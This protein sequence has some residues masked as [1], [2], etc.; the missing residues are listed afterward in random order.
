M[1][2]NYDSAKYYYIYNRK[3]VVSEEYGPMV[4]PRLCILGPGDDVS[5]KWQVFFLTVDEGKYC[6]ETINRYLE[7]MLPSSGYHVCPGIMK[8][9]HETI[10]FHTKNLREWGIPFINRVDSKQCELWHIP[11]NVHH[12]AGDQL[13]NTCQKCRFLHQDIQKLLK[14]SEAVSEEQKLARSSVGSKYPLKYLSPVTKAKRVSKVCRERV[15][16]TAKLVKVAHFDV[17]V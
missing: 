14:T 8:Y 9:P 6:S 16:L 15:T 13:H 4:N 11:N 7:Q 1:N 12:P 17:D 5:Y 10:R 2:S 3:P